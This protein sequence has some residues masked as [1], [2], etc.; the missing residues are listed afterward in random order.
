[1]AIKINRIYLNVQYLFLCVLITF[2]ERFSYSVIPLQS[3]L[4][5]QKLFKEIYNS[6][7]QKQNNC[8][9]FLYISEV[10]H[11]SPSFYSSFFLEVY[12]LLKFMKRLCWYQTQFKLLEVMVS[13]FKYNSQIRLDTIFNKCFRFEGIPLTLTS[14][15]EPAVSLFLNPEPNLVIQISS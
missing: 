6:W 10:F 2:N 13:S 3:L 15:S 1:M 14:L 4:I 11:S 7:I 12:W 9:I 5:L 8:L